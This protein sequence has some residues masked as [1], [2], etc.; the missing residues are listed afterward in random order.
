MTGRLETLKEFHDGGVRM[1]GLVHF[2]N[3]ELADS[4]TDPAG[5][6]WHGLSPEGRRFVAEANR[7]GMLL[8]ASHASDDVFDQ[9]IAYSAT[10]IILS[11]SGP[12]AVHDHPSQH[13]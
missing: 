13:R 6:K 10:P 1:L 9:L 4:A 11:H 2:A 7:L 12:R 8:D 5:P 3:N